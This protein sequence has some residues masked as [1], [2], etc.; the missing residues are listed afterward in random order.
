[1]TTTDLVDRLVE[2]RTVGAAPREELAW[3]ASHGSL[4]RLEPGQV[5]CLFV[6][7]AGRVFLL[8]DRGAGPH[9]LVEWRR[10]RHGTT[11]V[12]EADQCAGP[13]ALAGAD[14]DP[15]RASRDVRALIHECPE[16]TSILVHR[17]ADR[18]RPL[19]RR[20]GSPFRNS[21]DDGGA[22]PSREG[23]R[24][25]GTRRLPALGGRR[26]FGPQPDL[27][28]SGCGDAAARAN[29]MSAKTALPESVR[30]AQPDSP[31]QEAAKRDESGRPL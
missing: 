11:P 12:F 19:R 1:M 22:R 13:V 5:L 17:M 24:R 21:R 27:G 3:L 28:D 30:S 7:L 29:D 16:L 14:G 15:R 25:T 23:R 31:F 10:R 2:H 26:L 6:V 20:R 4:R 8:V 18:T 9:K